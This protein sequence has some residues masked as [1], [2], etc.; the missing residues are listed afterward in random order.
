M[1]KEVNITDLGEKYR[2]VGDIKT[3]ITSSNNRFFG[4]STQFNLESSGVSEEEVIKKMEFYII[5]LYNYLIQQDPNSL[6]P[7]QREYYQLLESLVEEV[8]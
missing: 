6:R 4:D 7:R 8:N 1:N 5:D 2:I 3:H